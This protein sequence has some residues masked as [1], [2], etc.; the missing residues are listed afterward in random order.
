L[1]NFL[2]F[3]GV[4]VSGACIWNN[5][6]IVRVKKE[7]DALIKKRGEAVHRSKGISVQAA[8]HLVRKEELE[9]AIRFLKC[10]VEKTDKGTMIN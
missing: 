3:L 8:P 6:D 7:L 4:N 10:L 2:D 5:Y 1:Q 9:T